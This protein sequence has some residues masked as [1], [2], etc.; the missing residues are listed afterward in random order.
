MEE[1]EIV[2]FDTNHDFQRN[3]IRLIMEEFET[4]KFGTNSRF[5]SNGFSMV[6]IR[7]PRME[8]RVICYVAF[9]RPPVQL[10][11]LSQVFAHL[12]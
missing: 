6:K 5:Q 8:H 3:T 7:G 2:Q 12:S 11:L 1:F 4:V 10:L 9:S